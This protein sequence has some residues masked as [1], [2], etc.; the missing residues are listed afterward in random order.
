[1]APVARNLDVVPC[2]SGPP[3]VT[4]KTTALELARLFLATGVNANSQLNMHRPARGGNSGRFADE[5]ITTVMT[6]GRASSLTET[7]S[8]RSSRARTGLRVGSTRAAKVRSQC[9]KKTGR[10]RGM[11]RDHGRIKSMPLRN[12]ADAVPTESHSSTARI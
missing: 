6:K 5:I 4:T 3:I 11:N 7:A 1:L 9:S 12:E 8:S 2:D 10:F